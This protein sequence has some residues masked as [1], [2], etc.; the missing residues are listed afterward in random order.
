MPALGGLEF[1]YTQ[2]SE[3]QQVSLVRKSLFSLGEPQGKK[4]L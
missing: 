4:S 2:E 3:S 1:S